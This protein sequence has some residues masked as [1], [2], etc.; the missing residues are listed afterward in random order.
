MPFSHAGDIPWVS[1]PV[2]L[3]GDDLLLA[4]PPE[5]TCMSEE[6]DACQ[7][8]GAAM[9][10]MSTERGHRLQAEI[11]SVRLPFAFRDEE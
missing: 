10:A 9:Q 2:R 8:S 11:S 3:D 5:E 4:E 7:A 1:L 6:A